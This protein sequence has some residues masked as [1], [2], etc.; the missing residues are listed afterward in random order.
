MQVLGEFEAIQPSGAKAPVILGR[1]MYGLKPVPFMKSLPFILTHYS[2]AASV[3]R[4]LAS[5]L[6]SKRLKPRPS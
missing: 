1:F 2:G 5:L 4:R 6:Q 3:W